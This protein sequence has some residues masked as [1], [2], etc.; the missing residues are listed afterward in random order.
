[1]HRREHLGLVAILTY[2]LIASLLFIILPLHFLEFSR[3]PFNLVLVLVDLCLVHVE[4][5]GHRLHL[6]SLLL[7]VR[8]VDRQLLSHLRT[9][10]PS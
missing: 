2:S 10:L 5:R 7:K 1:M 4:F 3:D 8:L 9:R 6:V